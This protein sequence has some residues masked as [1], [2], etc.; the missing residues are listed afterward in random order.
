M[1]DSKIEEWERKLLIK[2]GRSYKQDLRCI[3]Q[4]F[5]GKAL[6]ETKPSLV[7]K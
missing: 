7:A 4:N 3:D 2:S 6:P 5:M 1:K